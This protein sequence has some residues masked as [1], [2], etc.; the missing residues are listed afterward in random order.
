MNGY[1]HVLQPE[2]LRLVMELLEDPST[3]PAV[4]GEV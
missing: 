2:Q 3:P 4:R 1:V